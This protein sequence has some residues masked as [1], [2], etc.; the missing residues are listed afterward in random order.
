VGITAG[1]ENFK[2][3]KGVHATA[4]G[5][6]DDTTVKDLYAINSV[7]SGEEKKKSL[8]RPRKTRRLHLAHAMTTTTT[9]VLDFFFF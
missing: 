6:D 1:R 5:N 9:V 8:R 3:K 7:T 4:Y 2:K